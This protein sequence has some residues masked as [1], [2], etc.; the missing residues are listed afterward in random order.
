[1]TTCANEMTI[2]MCPPDNYGISAPDSE[3]HFANRFSEQSY[4]RYLKDPK[5]FRAEAITQWNAYY[6]ALK[7]EGVD[8]VLLQSQ[9]HHP[10][11]VFT[12]DQTLSLKC[13]DGRIVTLLSQF[14]NI[15]RQDEVAYCKQVLHG[16]DE[17]R[18]FETSHFKTEGTGDNYYDS[19]RDI[20]WSG[21]TTSPE[22]AQAA[23]GR[24]DKRA[25]D[26]LSALTGV[27]VVGLE[28]QDPFFHIDTCLAPLHDGHMLVFKQGMT[29]ASFDLFLKKAFKDYDLD[30]AE[31]LI[32]VTAEDAKKYGCNVRTIGK[33]IFI[34]SVSDR[35]EQQL[36]DKGY[37]VISLDVS[38]FIDGGGAM[39]CLTNLINESRVKGGRC[40]DY[41]I[42]KQSKTGKAV[43]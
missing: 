39:H 21:Y 42:S 3:G 33:T 4:D 30:P 37:T 8:V 22:R 31:Y 19:F 15:E 14:S 26:Q 2:L 12:A 40:V 10:D 5:T 11:L 16:F 17:T 25:H 18:L 24:S 6:K 23:A 9:P 7:A 32:E 20:Y 1:L 43:L 28:V 38:R 36:T 41:G 29:E 13:D 35:L 27:P 34:P